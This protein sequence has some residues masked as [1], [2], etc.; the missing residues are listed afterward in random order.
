MANNPNPYHIVGL[1][2][3][4]S[5]NLEKGASRGYNR[6]HDTLDQIKRHLTI[7]C[8][9]PLAI[10]G[11]QEGLELGEQRGKRT[12]SVQVYEGLLGGPES[13]DDLLSNKSIED[14]AA[15]VTQMQKRLRD[16]M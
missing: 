14:L 3:C 6:G 1:S 2:H 15:M 11:R 16:R 9:D 4:E 5:R 12:G 10:R 8:N 13:P 7:V